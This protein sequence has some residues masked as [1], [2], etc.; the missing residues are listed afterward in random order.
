MLISINQPAYLPWLGYFARIAQSDRHIVLDHVQFEKN[1]MVNRNKIR[2]TQGPCLL[3]VPL[4]TAGK[5]G[6]LAINTVQINNNLKWQKKHWQS[7][8]FNYKKTPF[9]AGYEEK[10]HDGYR[11]R[12]QNLGEL[13]QWQ[14][15]FFLDALNIKTELIYS[16]AKNYSQV[17]SDL[18][19]AICEDAAATGYLSG[20]FGKDYLDQSAFDRKGIAV[21]Y[22]DYQHPRYTQGQLEFV[23]HLSVL[24]LLCHHGP[25]SLAILLNADSS[26]Q[27]T[28]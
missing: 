25:Q 23:S 26:A 3:T 20:P 10:L 7:I 22:Q 11:Q 16:S 15:E 19:L 5:F 2:T 9:F 18:V 17:K 24:D 1:S 14:L 4:N 13:L 8:Y 12:W 27:Q 21:E 28:K 6:D